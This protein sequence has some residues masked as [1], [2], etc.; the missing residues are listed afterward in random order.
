VPSHAPT[1]T[2]DGPRDALEY[3]QMTSVSFETAARLGGHMTGVAQL[4]PT[5]RVTRPIE[6]HRVRWVVAVGAVLV[7][8]AALSSGFWRSGPQGE[9][10]D[11]G[12]VTGRFD[13]APGI[14]L[15]PAPAGAEPSIPAEAAYAARA[16][17]ATRPGE[18]G[19]PEV[20]FG[21]LHLDGAPNLG[22]APV[23]VV[24]RH[25]VPLDDA[26]DGTG[27]VESLEVFDGVTGD[28]VTSTMWTL[29]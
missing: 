11:R 4:E 29:S 10:V 18:K 12:R 9:F 8:L 24:L 15:E 2:I 6:V 28:P 23:W 1:P 27:Y 3:A 20:L 5:T 21:V 7:A 19:R 13:F 26:A 17:R 14:V 25:H 22:D 16:D